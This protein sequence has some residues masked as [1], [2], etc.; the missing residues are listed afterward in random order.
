VYFLANAAEL[1]KSLSR[2]PSEYWATNCYI[3]GSFL[4]PFEVAQRH[5]I[6]EGNLMWGADYPHQ[7]GTWPNTLLAIRYAFNE[8]PIQDVRRILGENAVQVF[9]LDSVVLH[10][11]ASR[12]GP[13]PLEISLPVDA[14]E[15]PE[16][17]GLAFREGGDFH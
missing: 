14:G 8:T 7:E 9:G 10:D 4:A 6:G 1:Q 11:V 2:K 5:S 3:G 12:I 16:H 17:R 13:T 15:I